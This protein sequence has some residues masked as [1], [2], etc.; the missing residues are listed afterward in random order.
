MRGNGPTYNEI[1]KRHPREHCYGFLAD[2]AVL[3]VQGMLRMLEEGAGRWNV[4]YANDKHHGAAVP[5]MPCMGGELVR[6]VGYLSPEYLVHLAIDN[7]WYEI[8]KR[9]DGLRYFE[10]LTYTH[11]NPVWG[12]APDDRTYSKARE[13]SFGYQELFRAWQHG[14]EMMR[15][16]ERVKAAQLRKAA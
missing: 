14:G 12:T 2:D 15:A 4:A 8:G 7:A 11:L 3:D 1:L 5:T 13:I 10:S 16:V 9:V 6:A